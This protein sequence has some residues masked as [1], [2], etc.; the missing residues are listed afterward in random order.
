[1]TD[2]P[3]SETDDVVLYQ[4]ADSLQRFVLVRNDRDQFGFRIDN[5]MGAPTGRWLT[6]DEIRDVIRKLQD[7]IA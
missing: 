3:E 6:R 1:M 4:H 2:W 7:A 5:K